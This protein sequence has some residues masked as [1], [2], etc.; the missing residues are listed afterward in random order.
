MAEN[1]FDDFLN[2]VES[3]EPASVETNQAE[4]QEDNSQA[5]Q[6]Q[7][8]DKPQEEVKEDN[9]LL[10]DKPPVDTDWFKENFEGYESPDDVKAKLASYD[11]LDKRYQDLSPVQTKYSDLQKEYEELKSSSYKDET[12]YK[13][14]KLEDEGER[15]IVASLIYG[16]AEPKD[17]LKLQFLKENPEYKEKMEKV[18]SIVMSKY[19]VD[20]LDEKDEDGEPIQSNI[21]KNRERLSII[22]DKIEHDAVR[23]K[24]ELLSN[25]NSIEMPKD[26]SDEDKQA[27]LQEK[28]A[29]I[30]KSN[31]KFVK[32]WD[33]PF[34]DVKSSFSE[35]L[36]ISDG[37]NEVEIPLSEEAQKEL[38][39]Y[40]ATTIMDNSVE[41]TEENVKDLKQAAENYYFLKNKQEILSK[42][43]ET[44]GEKA[45]NL[46]D[47]QWRSKVNNNSV[48]VNTDKT[49]SASDEKAKAWE[50]LLNL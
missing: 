19:N 40:V 25:Y 9:P 7:E 29:E 2:Q 23:A 35:K 45:R 38:I 42:F 43:A 6:N 47:E 12:L 22:E 32:S 49:T 13:L 3:G 8:E 26:A 30:K 16:N 39:N 50:K 15:K 5:E 33:K 11:D 14:D 36:K 44:V 31:A 41:P 10:Q 21:D 28:E 4:Q 24:R 27:K 48:D 18:D 20:L 17:I 1:A 34:T 37:E 46:S